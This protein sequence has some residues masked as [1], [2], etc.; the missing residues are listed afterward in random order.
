VYLKN[1]FQGISDGKIKRVF[2]GLEIGEL[3]QDVKFEDQLSEWEKNGMEI[4]K[5]YHKQLFGKSKG[6]KLL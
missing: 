1:K 2:V 4:I 6:R 5:K 3:I